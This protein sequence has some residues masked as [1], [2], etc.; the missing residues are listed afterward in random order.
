MA[1]T[2]I[3][4]IPEGDSRESQL[5]RSVSK[6]K[7][8]RVFEKR[9]HLVSAA[10]ISGKYPLYSPDNTLNTLHKQPAFHPDPHSS[11]NCIERGN[12]Q[13][14]P[15]LE[16]T[17]QCSA[18]H[19]CPLRQKTD[20][21]LMLQGIQVEWPGNQKCIVEHFDCPHTLGHRW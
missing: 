20:R 11:C 19:K 13:P 2:N 4:S 12:F 21:S 15:A 1:G 8:F 9:S 10:V 14:S 18:A 16:H 5:A 17:H 6:S 7:R 3:K